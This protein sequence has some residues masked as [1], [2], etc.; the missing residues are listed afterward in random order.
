MM[1]FTFGLL[2]VIK[3]LGPIHKAHRVAGKLMKRLAHT[4]WTSPAEINPRAFAAAFSD[5]SDTKE[6]QC[7]QWASETVP[8]GAESAE[9]TRAQRLSG[10]WEIVE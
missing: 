1:A 9:Q 3:N 6:A 2:L 5:W 4:F 10:S 7:L 8:V